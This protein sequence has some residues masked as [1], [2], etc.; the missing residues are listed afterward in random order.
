MVVFAVTLVKEELVVVSGVTTVE[1][2]LTEVL[3]MV[4]EPL[5]VVFAGA[6]DVMA[7]R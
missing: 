2:W 4:D 1:V 3:V 6:I 5:S 7:L